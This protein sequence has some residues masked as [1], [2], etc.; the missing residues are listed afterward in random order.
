MNA[1]EL[2]E[3]VRVAALRVASDRGLDASAL[4]TTVRLRRGSATDGDYTTTLALQAARPLGVEAQA[5]AD[6]LAEALARCPGIRSA[7]AAGPGFVNLVVEPPTGR[8]LLHDIVAGGAEYG[9]TGVE[10]DLAP[11]TDN[12]GVLAPSGAPVEAAELSELIGREAARYLKLRARPRSSVRLDVERWR[13]RTEDNPLFRVQYAHARL[14]ALARGA[15]ALDVTLPPRRP[16][17]PPRSHPADA[18]PARCA[19]TETKAADAEPAPATPAAG[20]RE[21]TELTRR[22]GE[23][24]SAVADAVPAR[25]DRVARYLEDLADAVR[26]P[27]DVGRLLPGGDQ[28]ATEDHGACLLLCVASQQVLNNGLA[29]LRLS[30]PERM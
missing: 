23:F 18:G 12:V 26:E 30:A 20:G 27:V 24:T 4:P 6:W 1:D 5:L 16:V 13:R 28:Q 21:D 14:S 29:L 9:V 3:L 25:P 11:H 17:E 15:V 8:D 19:A 7:T 22:L 2:T 10:L